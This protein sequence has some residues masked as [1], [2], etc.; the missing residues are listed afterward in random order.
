M[1]QTKIN[2]IQN[3]ESNFSR[4]GCVELIVDVVFEKNIST[5][6]MFIVKHS[7]IVYFLL[8][9]IISW[10]GWIP[11]IIITVASSSIQWMTLMTIGIIGPLLA[12]IITISIIH[13]KKGITEFLGR[14]FAW[15]VPY[16]WYL[17]AF[18]IA[19]IIWLL[20]TIIH[21]CLSGTPPV[22]FSKTPYIPSSCT[23]L[24]IHD[25]TLLCIILQFI[26]IFLINGITEEPGWRGTALPKLQEKYNAVFSSIIIGI[27]HACWHLP[28]YFIPGSTKYFAN[29]GKL[30]LPFISFVIVT[31][32]C[33]FIYTWLY[34]STE[35]ILFPMIFH[36]IWN[37]SI[38]LLRP[39]TAGYPVGYDVI[40][41]AVEFV[42]VLLLIHFFG[43]ERLTR[44]SRESDQN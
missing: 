14:I 30:L 8:A 18:A 34:N 9:Y 21:I 1:Y 17:A 13:G 16:I 38:E 26:T 29:T 25:N 37:L 12:S 39:P 27:I 7:L 36:T 42:W 22:L 23:F 19:V 33:S 41:I 24:Q 11:L 40:L 6:N 4:N 20:P 5:G 31:V 43:S 2:Y 3:Q 44:R 35:S 10:A 32:L 15:R 28:L